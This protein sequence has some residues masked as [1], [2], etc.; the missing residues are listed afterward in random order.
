[1]A[2]VWEG[3]DDWGGARGWKYLD[4]D[5]FLFGELFVLSHENLFGH[6]GSL[7][8]VDRRCEVVVEKDW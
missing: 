7:L 5:P 3:K 6:D 4:I 2:S 1:M 8:G